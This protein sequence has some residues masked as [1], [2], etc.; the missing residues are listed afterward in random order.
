MTTVQQPGT[1]REGLQPQEPGGW[2]YRPRHMHRQQLIVGMEERRQQVI[3]GMEE[4]RQQQQERDVH[5]EARAA[6]VV[7]GDVDSETS[8]VMA[9]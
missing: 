7:E 9:F 3:V 1:D 2:T 8:G 5:L 6:A 4:R